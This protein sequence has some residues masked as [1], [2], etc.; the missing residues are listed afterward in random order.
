MPW[1]EEAQTS[2][3]SELKKNSIL[4]EKSTKIK[5]EKSRENTPVLFQRPFHEKN[6]E[7]LKWEKIGKVRRL[8]STSISREKL[9]EINGINSCCLSSSS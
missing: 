6:I 2:D 4:R 7:K 5:L 1:L 9:P 8:I 3:E